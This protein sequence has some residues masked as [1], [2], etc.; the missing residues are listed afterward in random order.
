MK[1]PQSSQVLA[2][3]RGQPMARLWQGGIRGPGL[4]AEIAAPDFG[5]S[6]LYLVGRPRSRNPIV[7]QYPQDQAVPREAA[8]RLWRQVESMLPQDILPLIV[9]SAEELAEPAP[10]GALAR[11]SEIMTVW[12]QS[13]NQK[14]AGD[15]AGLYS[16]TFTFFEP[17]QKPLSIARR[18][19]WQALETESAAAGEIR[20]TI[21]D[22]L[23]MLDP[24]DGSRAWSVFSL[25]YDSKL[26]HDTGLRTLIFEKGQGNSWLIVAELW[27]KENS[28]KN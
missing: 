25:K 13:Q 21:S 11:I 28:L 2:V 26:R 10:G 15:M 24:R 22:P 14:R 18:N 23:I 12:T 27:L 20:L 17:G 5:G 19:F 1:L 6:G 9:G 4:K 16:E 7:F 8:D 3:E